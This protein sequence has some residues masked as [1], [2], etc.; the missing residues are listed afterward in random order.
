MPAKD[1]IHS[2]V[3]NALVK[4]GW[5]ITADPLTMKYGDTELYADLAAERL[6][7]A[8]RKDEKIAVEVKS[9]L[10]PSPV[11]ELEEALGQFQMYRAILQTMD[12]QRKVVLAI[13]DLI[14]ET[15]FQRPLF[16]LIV[17][18]YA[19]SLMVVNVLTEEVTSWKK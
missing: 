11:H 5:T 10:G 12:P 1:F 18:N 9:F 7:A 16:E 4:D 6:L 15:Q 14:F 19:I 8:E 2:A 17:Q 3:K 13:S